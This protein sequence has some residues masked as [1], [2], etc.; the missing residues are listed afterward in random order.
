[1]ESRTLGDYRLLELTEEREGQSI[2]IAEQASVGR[3]VRLME[4]TDPSLREKFLA[5]IRAKA[6]VD[7][8]L[9]SSV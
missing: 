1:M 3:R 6:A 5:D 4:L 2:W 8:P 7:H 9:I